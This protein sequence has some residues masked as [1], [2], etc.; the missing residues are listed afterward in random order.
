MSQEPFYL[1]TAARTGGCQVKGGEHSDEVIVFR[2][3]HGSHNLYICTAHVK[4][5]AEKAK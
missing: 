4:E 5:A 1:S 2:T 3:P